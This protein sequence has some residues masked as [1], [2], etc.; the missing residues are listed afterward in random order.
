MEISIARALTEINTL[1]S[2]ID[3]KINNGLFIAFLKKS[4]KKINNSY[5][6]DEFEKLAKA[7]YESINDLIERRRLIKSL[8][9]RSNANTI[10]NVDNKE[11][12]V[13]DAIERKNNI[14]V[15]EQLLAR[16]DNQYRTAISTVS[17]ENDKVDRNL[18]NLI[19]ASLSADTNKKDN[20]IQGFAEA[21]KND[22]YYEVIDILNLKEKI[23]ILKEEITN[24][25]SEINIVLTESNAITKITLPD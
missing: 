11:Y 2:R 16:L 23:D 17:R 12:C 25:K 22:N 5:T 1:D 13:A 24:F 10:V 7:T 3:D 6:R 14:E 8:I 15:E 20:S 18:D 21:Y 9:V 19:N 4:S